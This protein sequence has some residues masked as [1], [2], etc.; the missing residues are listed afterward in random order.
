MR[1]Q[2]TSSFF[3]I[4]LNTHSS[5]ESSGVGR[6]ILFLFASTYFKKRFNGEIGADCVHNLER[7]VIFFFL[8]TSFAKILD[9]I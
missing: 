4:L 8:E 5:E 1:G 6:L 9:R 2:I 7:S 3:Y